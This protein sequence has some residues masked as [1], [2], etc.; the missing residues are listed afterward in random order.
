MLNEAPQLLCT[1]HLTLNI[2]W[3]AQNEISSFNFVLLNPS[4]SEDK[5]KVFKCFSSLDVI[6]H[7]AG[8]LTASICCCLFAGSPLLKML[9]GSF[10]SGKFLQTLYEMVMLMISDASG[11][12]PAQWCSS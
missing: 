1:L 12:L 8:L 10:Y 9:S 11:L 5:C 2:L 3:M 7:R 4:H 6:S